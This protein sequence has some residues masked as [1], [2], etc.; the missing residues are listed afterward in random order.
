MR[1]YCCT[2]PAQIPSGDK[3]LFF[4]LDALRRILCQVGLQNGPD[5]EN[6]LVDT[7]M[8]CDSKMW[9]GR[10]VYER[11]RG[12]IRL[13]Q[14]YRKITTFKSFKLKTV[15]HY[16]VYIYI[17]PIRSKKCLPPAFHEQSTYGFE[18]QEAICY[19]VCKGKI[20]SPSGYLLHYKQ[21]WQ[22]DQFSWWFNKCLFLF[23]VILLNFV[24]K[25]TVFGNLDHLFLVQF[26]PE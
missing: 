2:K 14:A 1:W 16:T 4:L 24:L 3:S 23:F 11:E 20:S 9:K 21:T 5:G 15:F 19:S 17:F 22:A 26:N 13:V 7:L 10:C 18:V 6:S 12:F 25:Y 8:L